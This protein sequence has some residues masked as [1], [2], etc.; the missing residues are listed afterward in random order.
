M[1]LESW[2][3]IMVDSMKENGNQT[4]NMERG[5]KNLITNLFTKEIML[6]EN[7]KE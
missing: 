5:M 3:M 1:G 2:F 4:I 6:M 7:L